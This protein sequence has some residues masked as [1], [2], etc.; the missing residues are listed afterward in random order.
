VWSAVA[1]AGRTLVTIW[2]PVP[3]GVHAAENKAPIAMRPIEQVFFK[4]VPDLEEFYYRKTIGY[5]R[6]A[7]E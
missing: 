3:P 7:P 2:H 6:S 4:K 1:V 5:S